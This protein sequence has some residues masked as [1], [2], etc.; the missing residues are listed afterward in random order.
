MSE[1]CAG[2]GD[3]RAEGWSVGGVVIGLFDVGRLV[4]DILVVVVVMFHEVAIAS[5]NEKV[6]DGTEEP[7]RTDLFVAFHGG[8]T[9]NYVGGGANGWV[10]HGCCCF[11]N[12]Q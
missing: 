12:V 3:G 11:T 6:E 2:E 7:P 9:A 1:Y 5:W 4:F 10:G 8:D